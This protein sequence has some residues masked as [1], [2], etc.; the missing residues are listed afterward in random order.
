MPLSTAGKLN[1]K[2]TRKRK[3][4]QIHEK[5]IKI[6]YEKQKIPSE[7]REKQTGPMVHSRSSSRNNLT[8]NYVE[9]IICIKIKFLS[10]AKLK[11]ITKNRYKFHKNHFHMHNFMSIKISLSIGIKK[12]VINEK[13]YFS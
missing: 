5:V 2:Q 1:E 3:L 11:Y 4:E 12:E 9:L 8:F 6:N 13:N 7:N 10:K